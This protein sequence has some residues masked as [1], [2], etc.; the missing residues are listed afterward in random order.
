MPETS[1][2]SVSKNTRRRKRQGKKKPS[3]YQLQK[4]INAVNRKIND[5]VEYKYIDN[6]DTSVAMNTTASITLINGVAQGDSSTTRDG[7]RIVMKSLDARFHL[8]SADATNI[9]RVLIIQDKQHNGSSPVIGDILQNTSEPLSFLNKS[10]SK[11]FRTIYNGIFSVSN[12]SPATVQDVVHKDL[13]IITMFEGSGATAS[14]IKTNALY[15][16][17]LSDSGAVS[18][19]GLTYSIRIRFVDA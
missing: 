7:I 9:C 13:N 10:N 3:V 15:L 12:S 8:Q 16:V 2:M 14:T 4:Q 18:D 6:S 5:V 17:L 19:P 11:R 1:F